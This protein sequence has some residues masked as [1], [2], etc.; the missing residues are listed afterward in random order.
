MET[1]NKIS[2]FII[3][4]FLLFISLIGIKQETD[5]KEMKNEI[6]NLKIEINTIKN[7]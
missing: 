2:F 4:I 3:I 6:N 1:Q 5:I 7:N